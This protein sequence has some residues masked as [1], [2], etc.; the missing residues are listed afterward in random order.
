MGTEELDTHV[1]D[2]ILASEIFPVTGKE[3]HG[4]NFF[5]MLAVLKEAFGKNRVPIIEVEIF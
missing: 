3:Y 5:S 1:A 2:V 4:E